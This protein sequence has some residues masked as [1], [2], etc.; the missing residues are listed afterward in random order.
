MN[1][2]VH[3]EFATPEPAKEIDFF[4]SIF[5]WKIEQWGDQEYWLVTTGEDEAGIDGAIMPQQMPDQPRVVDTIGV[6]SIDDTI[7]RATAAGATLAMEKMEIP[8]MGWTAYLISPTGFMFGLF[9][10][11]TESAGQ[12]ST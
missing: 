5:G 7:A 2:V 6:E 1:R 8:T 3:F 10:T 4:R 12:P 9:E 11:M